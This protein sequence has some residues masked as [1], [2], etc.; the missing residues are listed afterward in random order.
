MGDVGKGIVELI[1]LNGIKD[2]IMGGA[3]DKHYKGYEA[4][5]KLS[6]NLSCSILVLCI[7]HRECLL[8]IFIASEIKIYTLLLI[9]P[10]CRPFG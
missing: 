3:L 5:R 4:H 6:I 9:G 2:L 1:F 7:I 10:N 8:S